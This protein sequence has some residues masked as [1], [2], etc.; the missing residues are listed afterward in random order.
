ME[1]YLSPA[2]Y[3]TCTIQFLVFNLLSALGKASPVVKALY[4]FIYSFI[5]PVPLTGLIWYTL[6]SWSCLTQQT[7]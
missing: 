7:L 2:N 1:S 5:H 3:F 6:G 4:K